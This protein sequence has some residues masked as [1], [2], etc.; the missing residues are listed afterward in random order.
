MIYRIRLFDIMYKKSF[1]FK[2]F[3]YKIN[4][5]ETIIMAEKTLGPSENRR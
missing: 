1:K 4:E 3:L 5:L 2:I